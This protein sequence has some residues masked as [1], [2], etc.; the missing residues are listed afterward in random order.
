MDITPHFPEKKASAPDT[1]K[2][3]RQHLRV[4]TVQKAPDRA[5]PALPGSA[6]PREQTRMGKCP[7][8]TLKPERPPERQGPGGTKTLRVAAPAMPPEGSRDG[9]LRTTV[10][11]S[12]HVTLAALRWGTSRWAP[13]WLRPRRRPGR[14]L[15]TRVTSDHS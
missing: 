8:S 10:H 15:G 7:A 6:A 13:G 2:V 3:K 14:C 11:R 9:P 1:L 12:G 4:Q 5:D